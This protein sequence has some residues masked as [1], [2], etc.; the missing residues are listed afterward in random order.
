MPPPTIATSRFIV[1]DIFYIIFSK[2]RAII[3]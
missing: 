2:K 3:Y 1:I